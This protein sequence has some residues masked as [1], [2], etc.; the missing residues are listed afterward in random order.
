MKFIALS[1]AVFVASAVGPSAFAYQG[2]CPT[3]YQPDGNCRSAQTSP[4]SP[5]QLMLDWDPAT[6]AAAL[7]YCARPEHQHAHT[8]G[9]VRCDK[10]TGL[11]SICTS[12]NP[13]P[14]FVAQCERWGVPD[15]AANR[16]FREAARQFAEAVYAQPEI[17]K[18]GLT[19]FFVDATADTAL[20]T[21]EK[22]AL[23][24]G[25]RTQIKAV[26]D[27]FRPPPGGIG[28]FKGSFKVSKH[29]VFAVSA[30]SKIRKI[31][32]TNA[33]Q[34]FR[35]LNDAPGIAAHCKADNVTLEQAVKLGSE[36]VAKVAKD[37]SCDISRR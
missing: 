17:S 27:D 21:A 15:V 16:D 10:I 23:S 34:A 9:D 20:K 29:L 19:P 26:F 37:Y 14:R 4:P 8:Y 5:V 3:G 36:V 24:K 25:C 13:T 18:T 31:H 22:L 30:I 7:A 11:Q 6:W 2:Q 1:L 32:D 28:A 33:C 35:H 12:P